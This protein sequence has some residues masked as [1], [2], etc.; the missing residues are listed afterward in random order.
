MVFGSGMGGLEVFQDNAVTCNTKSPRRVS[1]FFIPMAIANMAAGTMAMRLGWMG[2]NHTTVSACASS[3][4]AIMAAADQIRLGRC[5]VILAGGAEEA[6][7]PVALAGFTAM[8][9]LSTRNDEPQRASRP[10][11][12]H[13]DG[14]VVG[15]GAGTLV[16]ESYRHARARGAKILAQLAGYAATSDAYHMTAP[17]EDGEGVALCIRSALQ[18]AGIGPAD[19]GYVNTHGTSTPLGDVAEC[20]AIYRAFDGKTTHLK[21]NSTKSMIGHA[22]GAASAIEAV[23]TVKSLQEQRLHRTLNLEQQD[24]QIELDC[25]AEGPVEHAFAYAASNSFGFGGHNTTLI[26]R[27]P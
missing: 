18:D 16:L 23:V 4:H 19:I 3:N 24:P 22:L 10:F 13:R 9:A 21:I 25:C 5:D 17:R 7:C 11:D 2:P 6:V 26:F 8:K 20:R 14:F 15:E 1:P 12:L 27:R